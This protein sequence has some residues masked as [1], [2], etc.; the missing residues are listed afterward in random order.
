MS[1]FSKETIE[2]MKS[3]LGNARRD[4]LRKGVSISTGLTWYDLQAPAKNLYP[5]I[6]PM[7][8]SVPRVHRTHSG[9]ATNWKQ[10][11]RLVTGSG[12]DAMGWV[13]EGQ[14]SGTMS[15]VDRQ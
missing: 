6:T 9:T 8:N 12:F 14:R 11:T 4:E 5:I 2:M 3:S 7:R 10:V 1:N 15:Y 13:P